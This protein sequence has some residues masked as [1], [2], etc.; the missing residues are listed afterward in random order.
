MQTYGNL[1]VREA[2]HNLDE[3]LNALASPAPW[4]TSREYREEM[5]RQAERN[6]IAEEMSRL[7]KQHRARGAIR[8]KK[9]LSWIGGILL[10]AGISGV[11]LIRQARIF[12]T[13]FSNTGISNKIVEQ[14][15]ENRRA[16]KALI[17]QSD[18]SYIESEALRLFGLRKPSQSQRITMTLPD[19]DKTIYYSNS[20]LGS[21]K[22]SE[23][24]YKVLE[25][26]M[27][28]IK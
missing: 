17:E 16:N 23:G 12:K 10:I 11:L 9:L 8:T 13:N 2:F 7:R 24:N 14:L 22:K 25:A 28:A 1:A 21:S 5:E 4:Q 19:T 26:Y 27:K 6:R 18:T 20:F 3:Q 15:E